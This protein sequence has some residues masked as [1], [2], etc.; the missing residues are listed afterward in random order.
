MKKIFHLLHL[1]FRIT[2]ILFLFFV[3]P[4]VFIFSGCSA[5]WEIQNPYD[6]VDWR[7]HQQY[8][9]NLHTHTTQREGG[10]NPQ[11][12]VDKYHHLGYSILAITDHNEV[13]Y[14]WTSFSKM[15]AGARSIERLGKG[16]LNQDDLVYENRDPATLGMV[17]IQATELSRHHHMGSFFTDHTGT[18]TVEESLESTASKNGLVIFNHP[19]RYTSR[20]PN[21]YNVDWYIDYYQRYNNLAGAEIYNSGDRYPDDRQLW[22]SILTRLMPERPVWGF[23]NDDMHGERA[24]GRNWNVFILPELS[25]EWV[26]QGIEEGRFFYVYSPGGHNGTNPPRIESIKVNQRKGTIE[27]RATGQDSIRWI[28]GGDVVYKGHSIKLKNHLGVEDY[29]RV[30]IYGPG[31]TITGTQPFAIRRIR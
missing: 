4:L 19:G 13:T 30:E 1:S 12:V 9:A 27:I 28:S 11:T 10:M 15:K 16:Q 8:K 23:S 7:N 5:D 17:A 20:N 26:R 3:L 25:D 6:Q 24:L 29:I 2:L 14:P 18:A 22:D 31:K 21:I